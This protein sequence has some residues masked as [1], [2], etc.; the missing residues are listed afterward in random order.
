MVRFSRLLRN[1]CRR[2]GRTLRVRLGYPA[3][4]GLSRLQEQP[5][6]PACDDATRRPALSPQRTNALRAF[7]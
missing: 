1:R 6:S 5:L 4:R 7:A 3:P 2:H